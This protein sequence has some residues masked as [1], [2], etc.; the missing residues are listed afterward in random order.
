VVLEQELAVFVEHGR[1]STRGVDAGQLL[2]G[3]VGSQ[4]VD[5]VRHVADFGVL[6]EVK[7]LVVLSKQV[8]QAAGAGLCCGCWHGAEHD[9]LALGA[10]GEVRGVFGGEEGVVGGAPVGGPVL[11]SAR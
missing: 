6:S 7:H 10:S 8:R 5:E 3:F 4:A 9:E 11:E 1:K 2:V